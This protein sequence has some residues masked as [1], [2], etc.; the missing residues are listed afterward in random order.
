MSN[1]HIIKKVFDNEFD[2]EDMRKQILLKEEGKFR[3]KFLKYSFPICLIVIMFGILVFNNSFVFK[4][5]GSISVDN[6]GNGININK[7]DE[8]NSTEDIDGMAEDI[9]IQQVYYFYPKIKDIIIPNGLYNIRNIKMFSRNF[10]TKEYTIFDGLNIMYSNGDTKN[11]EI[12]ISKTLKEKRRCISIINGDYKTSFID[13]RELT[14]ISFGDKFIANF[15]Y[16]DIYFDIETNNISQNELILLLKS[17][18]N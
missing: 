10:S 17:I 4:E 8:I 13:G 3:S 18:I 1:K 16:E 12:F 11:I 5:K 7:I 2:A 6:L 15:K 9:T 14:I